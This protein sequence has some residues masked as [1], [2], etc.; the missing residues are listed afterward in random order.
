MPHHCNLPC[1]RFFGTRVGLS[2]HQRNCIHA[3]TL[4]DDDC[5]RSDASGSDDLSDSLKRPRTDDN[6]QLHEHIG[7]Q[8]ADEGSSRTCTSTKKRRLEPPQVFRPR[9]RAQS[10]LVDHGAHSRRNCLPEG[11]LPTEVLQENPLAVTPSQPDVEVT[12]PRLQ[13]D[14]FRT[15]PNAFGLYRVYTTPPLSIPDAGI[16]NAPILPASCH[17]PK[18]RRIRSVSEIIAPCPNISTFYYQ[19][20]HWISSGSI[21]SRESRNRF[22]RDVLQRPDFNLAD[23]RWDNLDPLDDQLAASARTRNPLCPESEG[24]KN[25]NLKIQIPPVRQ[26]KATLAKCPTPEPSF[27]TV[28]GLRA[29]KLTDIMRQ[30]FSMNNPSTFHY[31]TFKSFWNPP[32]SNQSHSMRT[33]GE[34][35]CSP[36]MI[37]AHREVQNLKIKDS[38][39]TLPRC[40]AGFMFASDG[41]QLGPFTH[42]KGWPI[43]GYFGNESKY[44]RCKP[45]TN[46]CYQIAHVPSLSDEVREQITALHNGRPPPEALITHL[47]RELMHE[48]WKYLIDADFIDAWNNGI[49]IECADGQKRRV[50]PRIL[51]YSAD[52]PEKVLLATIRNGGTCLCPRCT[53]KTHSVHQLGTPSDTRLRTVKRRVDN[54]K[55][56]GKVR[57]ARELIYKLGLSVQTKGVEE[58]LQGES[59]VPTLNAFSCNLGNTKFNIFSALVVDQ[60]HEIELG[61]FKSLFR[62]LV[63]IL[64]SCTSNSNIVE[65]NRRFRNVPTFGSTIRKFS[66]D[67]ASMGRLAA[68][69]LEDMLQSCIPVFKGL[70]PDICDEPAQRLLYL[71]AQWHGLAK[72]RLHTESTLKLLKK[73]TAQFGQEIRMFADLTGT[74]DVRETPK[75]HE[76]RNRQRGAIQMR[77]KSNRST[78]SK[79]DITEGRRKCVLNLATYKFH[80]MGDYV[81]CIEHFGT[82]DSYS[83]QINELHNR[84]IKLQYLLTNKRNPTAQMTDICDIKRVLLDMMD[85]LVDRDEQLNSLNKIASEVESDAIDSL[86]SG[87]GYSIGQSER[88]EDVIPSVIRWVGQHGDDDAMKFFIPQLKRHILLRILGS[89]NHPNYHDNKLDDL[90]IYKDQMHSHKTLRLNY[91]AYDVVRQQ[92]VVNPNS[93]MRFV[94]LPTERQDSP[95]QHPFLYAKILGI[96]HAKF[97]YEGQKTDRMDFVHVRWLYYDYAQPGGLDTC[98]LDRLS[99]EPC[100][101]DQDIL[102]SFDFV[103]PADIV[104]A[105]HLIPDFESQNSS[106]L[107][108]GPSIALDNQET[109]DWVCYYVN[110]FVDRDMLMRYIGGGVGHC[111]QRETEPTE[112]PDETDTAGIADILE[113]TPENEVEGT[114][115]LEGDSGLEKYHVDE[116]GD[117]SESEEYDHEGLES[118][119]ELDDEEGSN[120]DLEDRESE[121]WD[122]LYGF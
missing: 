38:N 59:Y 31:N 122:D 121:E 72:L 5:S 37:E 51:T 43:F 112:V 47:R 28:S 65:F 100:V 120:G 48:V 23:V 97:I 20:N 27:V 119:C 30:A 116:L 11:P 84:S 45:F 14:Q 41:L 77:S 35:Y 8:P 10:H 98:R 63:R 21:I 34:M 24:W 89:I 102:D 96:Y 7:Q 29:Q 81:R 64:Y 111:W 4:N 50:F 71:F 80:S 105:S 74:L 101:T 1:K 110:R 75:E 6:Q 26:T 104:R 117:E 114:D 88:S 18:P 13:F 46:S 76:R 36:A 90:R 15:E 109:G 19:H 42:M 82:C 17:A 70:L 99:Y 22:Q 106:E 62:H 69:D 25:V 49:E 39:C 78:S 9:T 16:A 53:I 61:V 92:D 56:R 60:L 113:L 44:E 3:R 73:V 86:L 79:A 54:E 107:L 93:A 67:V 118:E 40:V 87:V 95:T 55:R 57:K 32:G 58:L 91:T 52:Y 85:E 115:E 108:S 66:A 103:N 12:Q 83:T 68:R 94:M 2:R 33:S